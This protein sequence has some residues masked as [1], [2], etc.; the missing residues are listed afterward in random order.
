MLTLKELKVSS[1]K[2]RSTPNKAGKINIIDMNP[3]LSNKTFTVRGQARGSKGENYN[4]NLIFYGVEYSLTPG[5]LYPL[6]VR[7]RTDTLA[8]AKQLREDKHRVQI[9]CSCPSFKFD[10]AWWDKRDKSL[11]GRSFP[12][13]IRK[14][15]TRPPR[16]PG[17]YAGLCKHLTGLVE[18]LKKE[19]IL[20]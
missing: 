14:T 17:E 2:F 11:S 5:P 3:L 16:N 19:K 8:Y 15:L 13:Y 7:T 4:L 10:F 18:R 1:L 9:R 6:S 20:I 12:P